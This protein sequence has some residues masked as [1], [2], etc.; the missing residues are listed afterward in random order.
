MNKDGKGTERM[1][2]INITGQADSSLD[3]EKFDVILRKCPGKNVQN[4]VKDC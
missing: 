1:R 4:N 2:R 3:I